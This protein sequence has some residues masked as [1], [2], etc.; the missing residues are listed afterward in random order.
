M[1]PKS[2]VNLDTVLEPL[3]TIPTLVWDGENL[4][5]LLPGRTYNTGVNRSS[6][7]GFP[8]IRANQT[9]TAFGAG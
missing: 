2:F 6:A 1:T 4:L 5:V 9:C 7:F 8:F 3:G